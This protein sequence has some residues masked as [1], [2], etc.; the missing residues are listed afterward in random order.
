MKDHNS[1]TKQK[2]KSEL[3]RGFIITVASVRKSCRTF[4]LR[5]YISRLKK[6]GLNIQSEWK[7]N[8]DNVRYKEYYLCR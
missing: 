3:E 6:Y 5:T 2:I 8:E 1:S 4:D 7:K